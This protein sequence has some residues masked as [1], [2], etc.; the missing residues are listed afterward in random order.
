MISSWNHIPA[1]VTL[2]TAPTPGAGESAA[3]A[4]R[5]TNG[6]EVRLAGSANHAKTRSGDAAMVRST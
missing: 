3:Q 6:A 4:A 5:N 2:R 1:A